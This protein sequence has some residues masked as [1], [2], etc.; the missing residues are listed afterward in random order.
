MQTS[1][2]LLCTVTT[3]AL[4]CLAVL[5]CCELFVSGRLNI[6]EVLFFLFYFLDRQ[7]LKIVGLDL[8]PFSEKVEDH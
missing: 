2:L 6:K 3:Q 1:S 7:T 4:Q 8:S 5:S